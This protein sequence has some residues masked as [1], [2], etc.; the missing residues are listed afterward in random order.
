M[1]LARTI[2]LLLIAVVVIPLASFY[3][4]NPL[5]AIQKE[6]L[7]HSFYIM[8]G[9]SLLSFVVSEL[10]KNMSQV[11]KL[12]S[13]KPVIYSWYI[14]AAFHW[15]VRMIL[16]SVLVTLWG[17]RLTY[18]FGRRGGYSIKFWEGVEDYRWEV[19]RQEPALKG[20]FRFMMFN[21]FFISLYQNALVWLFTLPILFTANGIGSGLNIGDIV[22][23]VLLVAFIITE[24]IADQQQFEYQTE[25]HKKIAAG[26]TLQGNYAKGFIDTGLWAWCRHPNYASEQ[27]IWIVFYFFS[28]AATGVWFNWSGVGMVLLIIL[29]HSSADFSE[30]ISSKKYPLYA[31]YIKRVPRFI[32]SLKSLFSK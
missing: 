18:N 3:F 22:C 31:D 14:T 2:F 16:M 7:L 17:A 8:L 32:P 27:A 6:V 25:K 4:S 28:V 13:I 9:I 29:F 24:T 19:L 21:L 12:W 15:D 30:G 5:S 20:R 10:T 1:N 11:D 23:S 26:E